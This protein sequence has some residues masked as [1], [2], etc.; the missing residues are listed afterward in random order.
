MSR[1]YRPSTRDRIGDLVTGMR[2]DTSVVAGTTYLIQTQQEIFN[3]F[4]R[5]MIMELYCEVIT[6]MGAD[7]TTLQFNYTSST[8]GITVQDLSALSTDTFANSD[9]GD[10]MQ[11][12]GGAVATVVTLSA[13]ECIG[14]EHCAEPQIVGLESGIG[15]I[16]QLTAGANNT[17]GT[18]QFSIHYVPMSDGAYVT[19]AI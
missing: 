7:A 9:V 17:A 3:V 16:G 2:I 10:R 6:T 4:G 5:I 15:T 13:T 8:P 11:H 18:V 19:A 12:P 14:D 1:H